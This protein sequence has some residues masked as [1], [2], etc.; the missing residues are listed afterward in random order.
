MLRVHIYIKD[1]NGQNN[2]DLA[3]SVDPTNPAGL[4][5]TVLDLG[6]QAN[7]VHN[8]TFM[9]FESM[10][11]VF[12]DEKFITEWEEDICDSQTEA[13]VTLASTLD[14]YVG[15][16]VDFKKIEYV[17]HLDQN[18]IELSGLD[19]KIGCFEFDPALG[20]NS[21]D[22]VITDFAFNN[23]TSNC[24]RIEHCLQHCRMFNYVF[25]AVSENDCYCG[26]NFHVLTPSSNCDVN[27]ENSETSTVSGVFVYRSNMDYKICSACDTNP[28]VHGTC[29]NST[30]TVF[31]EYL[32]TCDSDHINVGSSDVCEIKIPCT[33]SPC[34]NSGSCTDNYWETTFTG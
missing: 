5:L 11:R 15:A 21:L 17:P 1:C 10:F 13:A 19:A 30:E 20:Q 24:T 28:C 31:T 2:F 4:V 33:E 26:N 34:Q 3:N 22:T 6:F 23:E 18:K 8:L 12:V 27:T 7:E 16:D 9:M 32:C 14:Y 25:A 29:A